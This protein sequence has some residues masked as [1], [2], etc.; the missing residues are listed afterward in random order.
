MLRYALSRGY[1]VSS[2]QDPWH[3][4]AKEIGSER[5]GGFLGRQTFQARLKRSINMRRDPSFGRLEVEVLSKA[6][7]IPKLFIHILCSYP[8]G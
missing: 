8:W 1:N 3:T 7:L 4:E 2:K 6:L 5:V